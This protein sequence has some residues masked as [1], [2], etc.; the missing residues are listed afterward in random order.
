MITVQFV[1]EVK[2]SSVRV[3]AT[4]TETVKTGVLTATEKKTV[5]EAVK[6]AHFM[7]KEGQFVDVLGG[8]G[9]VIIAGIGDKPSEKIFCDLGGRLSTKLSKDS[10]I[11]YYATGTHGVD[12]TQEAVQV[13]YGVLL[14]AYRF[15]KYLT[16]TKPEDKPALKKITIVV[17]NPTAA[18]AAFKEKQAI[19]DSVYMARDLCAEPANILNPKA[20]ADKI[21]DMKKVGLDI[22]ILTLKELKAQKFGMLLSVAQG[23]C[24]EPCVA[25][26]KWIGNPKKK[27]FDLGLVGKGVTFDSGGISLKPGAGMGDMKQDMTG[28]AVVT[29]TMRSVAARKVKSNVIGIVGLVENMPSGSATRPGDIVKS[30]SGQTVEILNTDAEGRLVLGDCLWYMQEKYGVKKIIDL[31]TLTGAVMVA[32]GEE[33]AGLFTNDDVFANELTEA[34]KK[35]GEAL[36]RLPMNRSY[37]KMLDSDIADMKNIG[38]RVAGGST[39]ACFLGRFIK[40]GTTWAHLDIAGVDKFEKSR[41]TCPKGAT[42]WGVGL[43]NNLIK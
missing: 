1:K 5:A 22:E 43:L 13:A 29:A 38:G 30:L 14:G 32:L 4:Q 6:Q 26:M 35:S 8:K 20:F 25:I 28:A 10:E 9:K 42:G 36:W 39:A 23:S 15:D 3:I 27:G 21:V 11:I 17:S 24:N 34:G 33:Y 18:K 37:N 31:A 41:P 7:A 2:N 19:A 16:K 12:E 40:E